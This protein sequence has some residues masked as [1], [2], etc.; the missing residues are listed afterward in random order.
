MPPIF[1]VRVWTDVSVGKQ[2]AAQLL[3]GGLLGLPGMVDWLAA[4]CDAMAFSALLLRASVS[5]HPMVLQVVPLVTP[6][7]VQSWSME[8]DVHAPG[9][10]SPLL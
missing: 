2:S 7:I 10:D 8:W 3:Q 1:D 4:V 9:R 6:Q 5:A